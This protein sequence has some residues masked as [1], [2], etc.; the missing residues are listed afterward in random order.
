MERRVFVQHVQTAVTR[1]G[2]PRSLGDHPLAS[3]LF[4]GIPAI[5]RGTE[6]SALLKLAIDELRPSDP[7]ET[8][9]GTTLNARSRRYQYLLQ[10]YCQGKRAA[11][12][13]QTLGLSERQARRIQTDAIDELAAIVWSMR[14]KSEESREPTP[15]GQAPDRGIR[16]ADGA[17]AEFDTEVRR[18]AATPSQGGV[19]IGDALKGAIETV[20]IL[21]EERGMHIATQPLPSL[22]LAAVERGVL[23]QVCVNLLVAAIESEADA[24]DISAQAT[25]SG[26]RISFRL[27]SATER[28]VAS[29]QRLGQSEPLDVVRRLLESQMGTLEVQE[30]NA[31]TA[32]IHVTVPARQPAC[33]LL[34][35]DNPDTLR[36]FRRYLSGATY[37][38][39]EAVNGRQALDLV[40]RAH[41]RAIILDIMMP[42]QDGWEILQIL[43][44]HLETATIPVVVCSVLRQRD[45]ALSL[46]ATDFIEKPVRRDALLG[47]LDRLLVAS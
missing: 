15:T 35:D 11:L 29:A 4:P 22:P 32:L 28:D 13:A 33:I 40:Q 38:T 37:R 25:D 44:S 30:A 3:L 24:V 16:Q 41:P 9:V 1:L 26:S 19:H 7:A 21:A 42:S 20:A 10:R 47:I 46:G 36:L 5:E 12:V 6:L 23:R 14:A 27:H 45:L 8:A 18:L 2:D 43:R 31:Q 39:I 34:V 17:T